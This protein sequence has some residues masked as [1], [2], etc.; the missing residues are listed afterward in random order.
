MDLKDAQELE[1]IEI[2]NRWAIAVANN[3]TN[4]DGKKLCAIFLDNS[5]LVSREPVVYAEIWPHS[6]FYCEKII[7]SRIGP[8]TM[9][10]GRK[11]L[12]ERLSHPTNDAA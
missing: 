8:F 11:H 9:E 1:I 10:K 3:A 6:Y 7:G 2:S 4:Y 5:A 12:Q